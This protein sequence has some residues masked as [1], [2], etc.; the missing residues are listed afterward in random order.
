[1][2]KYQIILADPP[3]PIK[4]QGS[5]SIGTK[6][7]EYPTMTIAELCNLPV[8]QIV[9][10]CSMLFIWTTNSFLPETLGII[11]FWGFQY[12]KLWT[13]CKPTGAGGHPRNATEHLVIARRGALITLDRHERAINNWTPAPTGRHSEK[14]QIFVDEIERLYPN[15]RRIELFARV[16]RFGW[17]SI[18]FDIEGCDIRESLDKL[19]T[20]KGI[21]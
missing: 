13:W 11:K 7:L 18:G 21:Y 17:D 1:M 20:L 4:W 15:T 10:D 16:K 19:V 3:Y 2:K 6:P 8:K 12:D 14:P 9:D 5:N